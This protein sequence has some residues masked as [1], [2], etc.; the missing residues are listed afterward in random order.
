MGPPRRRRPS[1]WMQVRM[2]TRRRV[3]VSE[4]A[5]RKDLLISDAHNLG[6]RGN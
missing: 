6:E 2:R 5:W 3:F 1:G 4:I